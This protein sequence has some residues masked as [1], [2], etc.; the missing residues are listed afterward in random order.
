M[1]LVNTTLYIFHDDIYCTTSNKR[2]FC[3]PHYTILGTNRYDK[4]YVNGFKKEVCQF[5]PKY[6]VIMQILFIFSYLIKSNLNTIPTIGHFPSRVYYWI[7]FSVNR[8]KLQRISSMHIL[9]TKFSAIL[10]LVEISKGAYIWIHTQT[11]KLN[12]FDNNL[13]ITVSNT[14]WESNNG[15]A[16]QYQCTTALFIL[17]FIVYSSNFI[18]YRAVSAPVCGNDAVGGVNTATKFFY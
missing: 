11:G 12:Y 6:H 7:A 2:A 4:Q 13:M 14:I 3:P 10:F 5:I 9:I 8:T 18:I 17:S 1:A 15:C 16:K